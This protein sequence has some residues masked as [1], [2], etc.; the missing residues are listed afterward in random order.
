MNKLNEYIIIKNKFS[1][2]GFLKP[3]SHKNKEYINDKDDYV[4]FD[5]INPIE[6]LSKMITILDNNNIKLSS[7][8]YKLG[9]SLINI[10][11]VK[12]TDRNEPFVSYIVEEFPGSAS[13]KLTANMKIFDDMV[14]NIKDLFK[15]YYHENIRS[16]PDIRSRIAQ[17]NNQPKKAPNI[18]D[19]FKFDI[20][21]LEKSQRYYEG[22][23]PKIIYEKD[24]KPIL[25]QKREISFTK[26]Y[27]LMISLGFDDIIPLTVYGHME[28][29]EKDQIG[30]FSVWLQNSEKCV[31][32]GYDFISRELAKQKD[33]NDYRQLIIMLTNI[34]RFS[35]S[36][37]QNF[38]CDFTNKKIYIID[39][40]TATFYPSCFGGNN[41][42]SCVKVEYFTKQMIEFLFK[43][44]E[45]ILKER[46]I[47]SIQQRYT[48]FTDIINILTLDDDDIY[49]TNFEIELFRHQMF[50]YMYHK[51]RDTEYLIDDKDVMPLVR[52][53]YEL[54]KIDY[55]IDY[56]KDMDFI[57]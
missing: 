25:I 41:V 20:T 48:G 33:M 24:N 5:L 38:V 1:E 17:M 13:F 3:F 23:M 7:F 15:H 55:D 35:D 54:R 57:S 8:Y 29:D 4:Y 16:Q 14:N 21:N 22:V 45:R 52:E 2:N 51:F 31:K 46:N 19:L 47:E 39:Q 9:H 34:I 44:D 28:Y 32:G 27:E 40:D 11:V 50:Y 53:I 36:H 43:Y 6:K 12:K 56:F 30:S 42:W 10:D 49:F 37:G 18:S 26:T